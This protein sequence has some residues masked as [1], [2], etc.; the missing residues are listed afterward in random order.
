MGMRYDAGQVITAMAT[1]FDKELKVDLAAAERLA[2]YLADNGSD[3]LIVAGSTGES[4]TLTHEEE[5]ELLGA[6]KSAVGGKVKVI[7]GAGSNSTE[8]AVSSSKKAQQKGADAIL[9]VVPYYNKP[10]HR[11]QI[12]H[13][14]SVAENVDIPVI[15]YNI[16]GRT[17]IN[18]CTAT[19]VELAEKYE[20]IVAVK[21]SNSDLDLVSDILANAPKGF[22][23]Y[24][25]DDSLT[26]PMIALGASGVVSVASHIVGKEI[27]EMIQSFV[28]GNPAR[29]RELHY[30]CLPLFKALFTSPNP[31]PLKASL[32]KLG[33]VYEG[34]R[35][36]LMTLTEEEKTELYKVLELY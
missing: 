35:P 24:S 10:N 17:G 30:K 18:M 27:K 6:V 13:F 23:L 1:P 15:I 20:N 19:I 5:L 21:Q 3:G 11:G 29:A 9:S 34:V 33:F 2:A 7:M 36:P 16:P 8:T 26:L 32:D 4:P 12:Y 25:G 14:S 22:A 31:I 28:A